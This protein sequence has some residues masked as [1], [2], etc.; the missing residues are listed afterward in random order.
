M[1]AE[2]RALAGRGKR[3]GGR[4]KREEGSGK[5][6]TGS[7]RSTYTRKTP[8]RFG[9]RLCRSTLLLLALPAS[10]FPPPASA[11]EARERRTVRRL[12]QLLECPLADLSDSLAGD[13]HQRADLLERHRIGALFEAVIKV[14]DLPLARCEVLP[15][16]AVDEL[17]HQMEVRHVLDLGAVHSGETLTQRA[18][19]AIRPIDRSVERDLRRRHLLGGTH[20]VGGLFEQTADLVV[21]GIAFQHLGENGL[22]PGKLDQLRILIERNS[23]APCL[24]SQRLENRLANPPHSIR[25]KLQDR[26]STRLNS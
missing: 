15:E 1:R 5:R 14:K 13:A 8:T 19:L 17:P 11:P 22:C 3:E 24:L 23:N 26:K 4:G 12:T 21:G 6:K 9:R 10:R 16:N 25:N 20:R 7:G 18:G 2:V